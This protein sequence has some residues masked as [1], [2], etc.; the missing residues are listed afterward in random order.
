MSPLP[1]LACL[2]ALTGP[3]FTLAASAR[4]PVEDFARAPLYVNLQL[5]PDG[6][7]V[8]FMR[9][10]GGRSFLCVNRIGEEKVARFQIGRAPAFGTEVD[11]EIEAFRWISD[12]RLIVTTTVWDYLYGTAAVDRDGRHWVG[13]TGR[14]FDPRGQHGTFAFE[15]IHAFNDARSR[16]LMLDR[17]IPDSAKRLFPNV[18]EVDTQAGSDRVVVKNPGNVVHWMADHAG[19]VRLGIARD[20][21]TSSV[22]YRESETR[23]WRALPLPTRGQDKLRPIG[24]D[25]TN[26]TFY[27]AG[28]N[29]QD[30]WCVFPFDLET[31]ARGEALVSDPVYDTAPTGTIAAFDGLPM[32]RLLFSASKQAII[33]LAYAGDSPRIRWLDTEFAKIQAAIDKALPDTV[34]LVAGLSRDDNRLLVVSF[35]DRH[36]GMF[37][38][39]DRA[40]RSFTPMAT[41]MPWIQPSQMSPTLS[42]KYHARDDLLIHGYL[43]VPVGHESKSLP[44]V[45]VPHGGPWVRDIW[46]F[47]PIAQLLASRGYAVLQMNYRGS[48]GYGSAFSM[49]GKKQVGRGI[50][51]DIEDA[52]RWAIDAGV[53][54]PAR[55]AIL[56]GSYGGYSALFALGNSPGMYRCGVSING[57]TD[58][59]EIFSRRERPEYQFARRRWIEQIGDPDEDEAFLRSISPVT[60]A[61]RIEAPVLIIQGKE[62][63]T[64]P[65]GQARD[66]VSALKKARRP[67]EALFLNGEGHRFT[68]EK[69][70]VAAYG[71]IVEFLEKHLGPG[72]E[73]RGK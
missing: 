38:L 53:A 8:A 52:T 22:L 72:V 64:V 65:P 14:E 16:I 40:A 6:S 69:S 32:A 54:D 70:R 21:D 61:D 60:F 57:V 29:E 36:P 33:G 66:M 37:H 9:E 62:D 44:L 12:A 15:L 17:R 56:G 71:A 31:G 48:P 34:N 73:Y 58:W 63:R 51:A 18:I 50:Q 20:E 7:S 26:D 39:L 47:D 24:F 3:S 42:I 49:A 5:S 67:P 27:V 4:V 23:E 41:R 1:R 11:K 68:K 13:L 19:A 28:F 59:L 10:F 55:I 35:S 46:G 2:L 43:T 45:V 25:A 30:R